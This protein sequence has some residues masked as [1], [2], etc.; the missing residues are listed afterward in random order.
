MDRSA[1]SCPPFPPPAPKQI[2]LFAQLDMHLFRLACVPRG[3]TTTTVNSTHIS[4]QCQIL[5][6]EKEKKSKGG[7]YVWRGRSDRPV[8]RLLC[9]QQSAKKC[10]RALE[11]VSKSI[12]CS[13]P[14]ISAAADGSA[15]S[16]CVLLCG[17]EGGA[18]MVAG[19]HMPKSDASPL[20]CS[21]VSHMNSSTGRH[22]HS[23][24]ALCTFFIA[25]L[26]LRVC[27][28]SCLCMV[29]TH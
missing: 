26:K 10:D 16:Y 5:L 8:M 3:T 24:L 28:C 18:V 20:I 21:S 2:P 13:C 9:Q 4:F 6:R 22:T 27:V 1:E 17:V 29:L 7:C 15:G 19:A 25:L 14:S 12:S 11:E 23:S